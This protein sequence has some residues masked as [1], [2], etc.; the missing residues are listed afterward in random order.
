VSEPMAS[1]DSAT[2]AAGRAAMLTSVG[3][4]AGVLLLRAD[5]LGAPW[6]DV[7]A[8]AL[9]GALGAGVA[10]WTDP[11]WSSGVP[12]GRDPHR[13]KQEFLATV[14]HELR[15]PLNAILGWTELLRT[16]RG[17]PAQQ[18][19]RGLEVIERNA[20]RQLAL[21]EELLTA[22]E[23]AA[24][25]RDWT[26]IDIDE[27]LRQEVERFRATAAAARVTLADE[28]EEAGTHPPVW[29][30]G[31]GPSLGLALRHVIDNAIKFTPPGGRV[32]TRLRQ[33]GDRVL[34]F[35]TDTGAGIEP[36]RLAEVFEPFAQQDGSTA[37]A[38]GGL[39]LGLTIA[40]TLVERHGGH[41]DLRSEGSGGGATV[42]VTL[43]AD[44]A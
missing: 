24:D 37:R 11:R 2:R 3:V 34:I 40:R 27:R 38:H 42:L 35:V 28:P 36:R 5:V 21:V 13:V 39:G 15:T 1:W 12:R 31:D 44:R 22:A 25:P 29:V 8:L 33:A 32:E 26:P 7:V 4:A 9:L 43:P 18:V 20:R 19:D 30:R 41:L 6:I 17:L 16:P 10:V 23:P 14:S